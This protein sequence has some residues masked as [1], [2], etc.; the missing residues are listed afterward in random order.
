[1]A[2]CNARSDKEGIYYQRISGPPYKIPSMFFMPAESTSTPKGLF[3]YNGS[4]PFT[5]TN[6][7]FPSFSKLGEGHF[8]SRNG[9]S[10]ERSHLY[11]TSPKQENITVREIKN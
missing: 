4:V 9:R 1:M 5:H 8:H 7:P 2:L 11:Q 10:T 3:G 6:R